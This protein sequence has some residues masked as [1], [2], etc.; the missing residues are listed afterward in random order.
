MSQKPL[1][2]Q[3]IEI[4]GNQLALLWSDGREDY[5]PHHFLRMYSPSAENP[6]KLGEIGASSFLKTTVRKYADVSLVG[7]QIIGGYA[8]QLYFNDG[9]HTGIYSFEYLR[10]LGDL[11]RFQNL[12]SG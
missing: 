12:S 10:Q 11:L 9:H 6:E 1:A 2:V 7:W 5:F 8:I 4:I 3:K